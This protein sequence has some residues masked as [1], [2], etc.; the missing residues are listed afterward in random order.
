MTFSKDCIYNPEHPNYQIMQE[1]MEMLKQPG[2]SVAERSRVSTERT[3]LSLFQPDKHNQYFSLPIHKKMSVV[4]LNYF[5]RELHVFDVT[6][7]L[8]LITAPAL[9]LCGRHDVQ[10]PVSYSFEMAEEIPQSQLEIFE[11]SNHYP[12]LE[13]KEL[14]CEAVKRFTKQLAGQGPNHGR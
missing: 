8:K 10:C 11:E 6:R 13:E 14:F 9:I 2:L 5:S 12:F 4:R 1:Y 3:K 7:K